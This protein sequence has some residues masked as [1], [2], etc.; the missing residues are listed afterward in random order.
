MPMWT[1]L[2]FVGIGMLMDPMRVCIAAV[3]ASR[4][5][6]MM[7]LLAFWVGGLVA[8]AAVG[9]AVLVILRETA[10]VA[11]QTA[12]AAMNEVRAAVGL[13]ES[14]RLQICFG[15]MALTGL[16]VVRARQRARVP[17]P[18]GVGGG[19]GADTDLQAAQPAKTS[20]VARLGAA[21]KALVESGGHWPAFIA[22][23]A[24]TF[25]PIEGPIALTVIMAS[26]SPLTTQLAGFIVF[27]LLMLVFVEIP[28]VGYLV[29]PERT[30][31]LM[32]S[33]NTWVNTYR[34]EILQVSLGVVGVLMLY[35]G[36]S[37]L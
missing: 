25:P 5:R 2:T 4:R 8:C 27:T 14:G 15:V 16:L 9:I 10:V 18:V 34:L 21:A 35:Q 28:L 23:L 26:K 22:G 11:I 32:H 24:S 12:V 13:L 30:L 31:A 1:Y 37:R 17:I 33:L 19:H 3:L 20:I 7:N 36:F 6:A 29:A